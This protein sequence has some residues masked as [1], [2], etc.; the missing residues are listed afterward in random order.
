LVQELFLVKFF[1]AGCV[2]LGLWWSCLWAVAVNLQVCISIIKWVVRLRGHPVFWIN[3]RYSK[4]KSIPSLAS[5]VEN[6]TKSVIFPH[7]NLQNIVCTN[8]INKNRATV[9]PARNVWNVWLPVRMG[10]WHIRFNKLRF[11]F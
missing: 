4:S 8:R 9:I 5:S 7:L 10:V 6:V 11:L 2:R 3:G 1:V